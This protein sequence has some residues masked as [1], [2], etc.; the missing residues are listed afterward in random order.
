MYYEDVAGFVFAG[1]LVGGLITAYFFWIYCARDYY[2]APADDSGP[3]DG[4]LDS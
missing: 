1:L 3:A 2:H 4:P